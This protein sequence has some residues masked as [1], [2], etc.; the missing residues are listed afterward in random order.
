MNPKLLSKTL[1][2]FRVKVLG[3]IQS[4][5]PTGMRRNPLPIRCEGS[6]LEKGN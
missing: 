4:R 1:Y 5:L 2:A 3:N 6:V